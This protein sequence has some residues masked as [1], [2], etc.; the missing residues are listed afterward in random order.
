VI[1]DA[2]A[3]RSRL[4]EGEELRVT[5]V[6]SHG[7]GP[8][9]ILGGNLV[10]AGGTTLTAFS[11]E[12]AG[13]YTAILDWAAIHAATAI[14]FEDSE[15]RVF[16]ARFFDARGRMVEREVAVD[17]HCEGDAA[18]DGRCVDLLA[19]AEHCGSCGHGCELEE[20]ATGC[21]EG[22]CV[23]LQATRRRESCAD[24]CERGGHVCAN[25]CQFTTACGGGC[26][27]P[28]ASFYRDAD[29]FTEVRPGDEAA[30][31]T[32]YALLSRS[33]NNWITADT[34]SCDQVPPAERS[35]YDF[36]V[37]VCCCEQAP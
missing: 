25:L 12:A 15:R 30:V 35:F 34:A 21:V 2:G 31:S 8:D 24:T 28:D 9:A 26:N 32:H 19:D 27:G 17:L 5:A 33:G 7:G 4:T 1:L 13:S 16:R 6:V 37:T 36:D 11:R 3:S 18:C 22:R 14:D 20:T 10:D 23:A 29:N